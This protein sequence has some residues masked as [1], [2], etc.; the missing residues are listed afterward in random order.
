MSMTRKYL[1]VTDIVV[2]GR[3][4]VTIKRHEYCSHRVEIR[5]YLEVTDIIV[6]SPTY[7]NN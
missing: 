7:V 1:E 5:K 2:T 3:T 6:T 4:N